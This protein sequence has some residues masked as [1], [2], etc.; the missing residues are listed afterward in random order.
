MAELHR[1]VSGL[2][3]RGRLSASIGAVCGV[4]CAI[5][6]SP[7]AR[8]QN[9]A[10]T[11]PTAAELQGWVH[12]L[13]AEDIRQR[14]AAYGAL[15][16]LD[17]DALPSI[18]ARLVV[19]ARRQLD[20]EQAT[21]TLTDF[22][23]AAGSRRADDDTDIAP[24][25]LGV[26]ETR[27]EPIVMQMAEP[28]LL[29]RSLEHIGSVEAIG[30]IGKLCGLDGGIWMTEGRRAIV[31]LGNNAI[32][33]L[34]ES[35]LSDSPA[36]RSWGRWGL[37]QLAVS[38]P[39]TV[40]QGKDSA[41]LADILRAWGRVL[42]F[43]AMRV[44]ISYVGSERT[45]VRDAAR[46]TIERYGRNAVWQLRQ[47]YQNF[48][49]TQ[50]VAGWGWRKLMEALFQALDDARLAGVSVWLD[51][52]LAA[53]R[54]GNLGAM[55]ELYDRVLLRAPHHERRAEMAP[56]YAALAHAR[57]ERDDLVGAA[58]ALARAVRLAPGNARASQWRAELE[59]VEGE[60]SLAH[61]VVDLEAYR[62]AL[63]LAPDHAAAAD[64]LET[65]TG[66][67]AAHAARVRTWLSILAALALAIAGVMLLRR[68]RR[69]VLTGAEAPST[70]PDSTGPDGEQATLAG[71]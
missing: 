1:R 50:P 65:L 54:A 34:I 18:D 14:R 60:R 56:G 39:G 23:H 57:L 10:H 58:A 21:D 11:A 64:A 30:R 22:R 41:L 29:M 15:S 43:D 46:W 8:A 59:Y 24:G 63:A 28:L 36:A 70:I 71:G 52:G 12:R 48:T 47:A 49:G 66:E 67:R 53:A 20:A 2:P 27:R 40:V 3:H 6:P 33:A 9:V 68:G 51:Q 69:A 25:V 31:R 45:E 4:L 26:L 55:R 19:L 7:V 35:K 44:V 13:G 37:R 5:G 61:G 38:S 42:D 16:T 32:P 62:R 17:E